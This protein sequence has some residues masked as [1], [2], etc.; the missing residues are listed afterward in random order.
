MTQ[1]KATPYGRDQNGLN[2]LDRRVYARLLE[3]AEAGIRVAPSQSDLAATLGVSHPMPGK[4][5][6]RLEAR[7]F[8][9]RRKDGL[10]IEATGAFLRFNAPTRGADGLTDRERQVLNALR[11][12]A[13][14]GGTIAFK[15]IAASLGVHNSRVTALLESLARLG[16]IRLVGPAKNRTIVLV[17]SGQLLTRG[18]L[19]DDDLLL[20]YLKD[21]HAKALGM[22]GMAAMRGHFDWTETAIKKALTRLCRAGALARVK[23][24][25]RLTGLEIVGVGL[26]GRPA[27]PPRPRLAL[28]RR[29]RPPGPPKPKPAPKPFRL[30]LCCRLGLGRAGGRIVFDAVPG[31]GAEG[32]PAG[33]SPGDASGGKEGQRHG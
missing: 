28:R 7:G 12:A 18:A 32:G 26:L 24:G 19:V 9:A 27:K 20:R 4:A 25:G 29:G 13:D 31:G 11:R 14:A 30:C 10:A 17:A 5:L 22:P 23:T 15:A 16:R 2:A 8:I 21:R 3:T 1:R 33:A 6:R